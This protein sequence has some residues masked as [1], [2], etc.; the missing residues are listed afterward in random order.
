MNIG[1]FFCLYEWAYI[2][3]NCN[4]S[5]CA[6]GGALVFYVTCTNRTDTGITLSTLFS[7]KI[8]LTID[9]ILHMLWWI[10]IKLCILNVT[11]KSYDDVK[12]HTKVKCHLCSICNVQVQFEPIFVYGCTCNMEKFVGASKRSG[13][14]M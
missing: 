10:S 5:F 14:L 4:M 13:H 2:S 8:R 11:C 6:V 7:I 1:R 9:C 12:C 3:V